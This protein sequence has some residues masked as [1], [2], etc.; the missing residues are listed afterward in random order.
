MNNNI[1]SDMEIVE[2]SNELINLINQDGS[3]TVNEELKNSGF[4][5]EINTI[6]QACQLFSNFL[7][8]EIF[9]SVINSNIGNNE[10][11]LKLGTALVFQLRQFITGQSLQFVLA[12]TAK[13]QTLKE[14]TYS[15]DEIFSKK[16]LS[17][18]RI[19]FHRA[20]IELAS[21]IEKLSALDDAN[22]SLAEQWK[23]ILNYGFVKNPKFEEDLGDGLYHKSGPDL[24]VYMKYITEEGKRRSLLYYYMIDGT[25]PKSR[26][27][28][29]SGKYYDRGW[30]YQWL[31]M[32]QNVFIDDN[33]KYPLYNLMTGKDSFQEN[34][35]GIKSGDSGTEQYKFRNRR[36]ITLRNIQN[37][38]LGG[39]GYIGII[40]SLQK[41]LSEWN[42]PSE[43]LGQL[44]K[45]FTTLNENEIQSFVK[46]RAKELQIFSK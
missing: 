20:Q 22:I 7:N 38:L 29:K 39:N 1:L 14:K 16:G 10:R 26:D 35:A 3:A 41:L 19:S 43:A 17:N 32:N 36:I 42:T 31:K 28:L 8:T 37:I 21:S 12:G 34:I 15:Q 9:P 30:M 44:V 5:I 23:K 18:F 40:P 24:N 13:G 6:L 27:D 46:Q 25:V 4:Q 11:I 33:S 45:D 2:I